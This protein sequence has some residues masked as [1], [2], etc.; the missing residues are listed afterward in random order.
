VYRSGNAVG[1]SSADYGSHRIHERTLIT[2]KKN[3]ELGALEIQADDTGVHCVII[4]RLGLHTAAQVAAVNDSVSM[5][6]DYCL[7]RLADRAK[8]NA[9]AAFQL[10][11]L[12]R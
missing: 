9:R 6:R 2:N 4:G 10:Q 12:A 11:K 7:R 8:T 5:V 3:R 1:V